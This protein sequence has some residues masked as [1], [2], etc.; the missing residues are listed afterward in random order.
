MPTRLVIILI[1]LIDLEE[2]RRLKVQL[3]DSLKAAKI[4]LFLS[5]TRPLLHVYGR[6][7]TACPLFKQKPMKAI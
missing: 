4:G 1:L 7:L 5:Q 3:H 2:D 6:I